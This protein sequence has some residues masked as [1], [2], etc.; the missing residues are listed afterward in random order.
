MEERE[1]GM[2]LGE[3]LSLMFKKKLILL[4]ITL[5]VAVIGI[6]GI[7]AIYNPMKKTTTVEFYYSKT[8]LADGSYANGKAFQVKDIIS[9]KNVNDVIAS[10]EEYNV[11]DA[12]SVYSGLKIDTVQEVDEEKKVKTFYKITISSKLLKNDA[13]GKKFL[14]DLIN[15]PVKKD[16][17]IIEELDLKKELNKYDE[18]KTYEDAFGYLDSANKKFVEEFN[19]LIETYGDVLYKDKAGTTKL[20]SSRLLDAQVYIK[21]LDLN[22][23]YTTEN[24]SKGGLIIDYGLILDYTFSKQSIQNE[25]NEINDRLDVVQKQ[26]DSINEQY[27]MIKDMQQS[28]QIVVDDGAQNVIQKQADLSNQKVQLVKQKEKV[29]LRLENETKTNVYVGSRGVKSESQY[30]ALSAEEKASYE[31]ISIAESKTQIK[32]KLD[33]M[34]NYLS[35]Q[36]DLI[37]QIKLDLNSDSTYVY[38]QSNTITKTSGG[39]NVY[40]AVILSL[41]IGLVVGCIV[42]FALSYSDFKAKKEAELAEKEQERIKKQITYRK[43]LKES[44]IEVEEKNN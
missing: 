6:V 32:N 11:L 27:Q 19:K 24:G 33:Q 29:E 31:A 25:L 30:N 42:S 18:A 37:E 23:L 28:G 41:L 21:N 10:N 14:V 9:E 4:I 39:L 17:E 22:T 5:V 13:L 7:I 3:I 16:G 35:S 8:T 15:F 12:N 26:I 2:S 38:Y 20:F 40:L 44:D 1:E 34:K 36:F 43:M